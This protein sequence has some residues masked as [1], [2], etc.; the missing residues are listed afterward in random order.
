MAAQEIQPRRR[1]AAFDIRMIIALL[2]GVYGVV[3]TV[4]GLW[5]TTDEE[6]QRS[7]GVNI[8]LWAGICM[9]VA[10]L[11]FVAWALIR[12]LR[13]PGQAEPEE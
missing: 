4:L 11:L 7:A 5:F 9:V 8:N 6:I 12:P 2:M 1:G 10:A 3:L 13:V